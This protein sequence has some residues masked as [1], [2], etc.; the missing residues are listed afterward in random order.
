MDALRN[1]YTILVSHGCMEQAEPLVTLLGRS[2][3]SCQLAECPADGIADQLP[4]VDSF[5]LALLFTEA[6]G[7]SSE[8]ILKQIVASGNEIPCFI[9]SPSPVRHLPLMNQGAAA[10]ISANQLT[11]QGGQIQ[12]VYQ[13]R[14]ELSQLNF[15][16]ENRR[17]SNS[18][19][20]MEQR[21]SSLMSQSPLAVATIKNGWHKE[22]NEAWQQFFG[23]DDQDAVQ[24]VPFLDLVAEQDVE[25]VREFLNKTPLQAGGYCEFEAS[26]A[27][28]TTFNAL[29][30]QHA[31]YNNGK[32]YIQLTARERSGNPAHDKEIQDARQRDLLSGL[33]NETH[34]TRCVD[35][36]ISEAIYHHQ[37]SC[38]IL[39][40]IP[41]MTEASTVLGKNDTWLLT[42]DIASQLK[43]QCPDDAQIGRLDSGDFVIVLPGS[44]MM[45]DQ[46][47]LTRLEELQS[48]IQTLL[49]VG[50]TLTFHCGS[51]L[52]T[53]EAPDAETL[54]IRARQH[55]SARQMQLQLPSQGG[56][57]D[58]EKT[59][60]SS[61][62]REAVEQESLQIVYQSI[63][64]LQTDW[65]PWFEVRIRLPIG[66]QVLLP[67]SFI[68]QA[69]Q[70][71]YGEKI[72]RY[73]LSKAINVLAEHK[74]SK[75][76]LIVNL[77]ANSLTS[78]TLLVWLTREL[79][80]Y[81]QGP[82][83]LILQ[84]SEP[85]SLNALERVR[86]FTENAIGLGFEISISQFGCSLDPLRLVDQ[87]N[88]TYA[89]LDKVMLHHIDMDAPQRERLQDV[90]N[91]LHSKNIRVIAPLIEDIELLPL[92]WQLDINYVQ[93]YALQTPSEQLETGLFVPASISS[94]GDN[95]PPVNLQ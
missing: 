66:S 41:G 13:L 71:G 33:F 52:V 62:L 63:V 56:L 69:N 26:R 79:E 15:R 65:S 4:G 49:P 73:V 77:T 3:M 74:E 32:A 58:S 87:L 81:R 88:V 51:A 36:A 55:Q 35:Q 60:V 91:H 1:N 45:P 75:L 22:T 5:D 38:L 19:R 47:L 23:F 27:D 34:I 50:L 30:Q 9:I 16:R 94:S 7:L 61:Q 95:S 72:D 43:A 84:I 68:D 85:D 83:K 14:R 12:L 42:R 17:L 59:D 57:Q 8:A 2:G 18:V 20:E 70:H 92:L 76:R 6:T 29:L 39:L 24:S 37:F 48:T 21:L 64:S 10:V 44:S 86:Q 67:H 90:V 89:K 53:D 46:E 31:I 82:E 80:K 28:G 78:Q 11:S 93:G 40:S 54:F 25:K